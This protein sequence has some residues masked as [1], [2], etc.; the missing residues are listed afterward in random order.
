MNENVERMAAGIVESIEGSGENW[1]EVMQACERK[2]SQLRKWYAENADRL[3][4]AAAQ[5]AAK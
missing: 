1:E 2:L 3:S 5:R 4:E